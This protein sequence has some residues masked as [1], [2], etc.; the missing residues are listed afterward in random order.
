MKDSEIIILAV[1]AAGAAYLLM[2]NSSASATSSKRAP[3]YVLKIGNPAAGTS[4]PGYGWQYFTDGTAIDPA[5]NYY[6]NGEKVWSNPAS[7]GEW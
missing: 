1:A 2:R 5:G 6:L 3:G 7:G 4:D